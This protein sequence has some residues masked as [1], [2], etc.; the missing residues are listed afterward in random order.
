MTVSG[1]TTINAVRQL[2]QIRAT[3]IQKESV[4]GL[5][6]ASR[7]SAV[8]RQLLPQGE[9]L[10]DQFSVAAKNQGQRA[11]DHDEQLQHAEIVAGVAAKFNSDEF[12]QWSGTKTV[13]DLVVVE[14]RVIASLDERPLWRIP[15]QSLRNNE[16]LCA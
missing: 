2:R 1:C 8:G 14:P 10:Q 16:T 7:R 13:T 12:W 11:D 15:G 9:V 3:A 6:T 4:A 5:E